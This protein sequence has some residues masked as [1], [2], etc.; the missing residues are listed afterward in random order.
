MTRGHEEVSISQARLR[1]GTPWE[2]PTASNLVAAMPIEELR[3]D[4][5][6]PTKI[7]MEM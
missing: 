2:T 4:N 6:I 3:L 7:S 1:R 5:Q